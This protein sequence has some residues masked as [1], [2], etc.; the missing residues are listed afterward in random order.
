[1]EYRAF[2]FDPETG[3]HR[4]IPATAEGAIEQL[5]L[6]GEAK[7]FGWS[8]V[9]RQLRSYIHR[10]YSTPYM[11]WASDF[12]QV[13]GR[14]PRTEAECRWGL[15]SLLASIMLGLPPEE[16]QRDYTPEFLLWVLNIRDLRY[17]AEVRKHEAAELAELNHKLAEKKRRVER[18]KE[19]AS[20]VSRRRQKSA[21]RANR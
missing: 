10:L 15:A 6:E 17:T 21:R 19:F 9:G 14:L 8:G 7:K 18:E 13:F 11:R 3:L 1:M 16:Y 2:V 5:S 4:V 12:Y 20:K